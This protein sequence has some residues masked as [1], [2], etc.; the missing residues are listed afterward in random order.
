MGRKEKGRGGDGRESDLKL[1][2]STC[3]AA[4][5]REKEKPKSRELGASDL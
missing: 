4:L 1:A 5:K 2:P 3:G